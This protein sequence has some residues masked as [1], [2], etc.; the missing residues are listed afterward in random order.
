M[1][2]D[3]LARRD[4]RDDDEERWKVLVSPS[5]GITIAVGIVAYFDVTWAFPMLTSGIS[6]ASY[7][8]HLL[9]LSLPPIIEGG[10]AFTIEIV[11]TIILGLHFGIKKEKKHDNKHPKN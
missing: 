8:W 11:I 1:W 5:I 6:Q 10:A 4:D 7:A 9:T 2:R 3:Y